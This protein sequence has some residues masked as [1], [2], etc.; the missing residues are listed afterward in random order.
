MPIPSHLRTLGSLWFDNLT[1]HR[2]VWNRNQRRY[3]EAPSP[4]VPPTKQKAVIGP[5]NQPLGSTPYSSLH[6]V[7]VIVRVS[8]DRFIVIVG[9]EAI[10]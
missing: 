8:V 10:R 4:L 1:N 2:S 3:L 6:G 9:I 5:V 7:F